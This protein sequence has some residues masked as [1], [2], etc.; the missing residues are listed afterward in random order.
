MEEKKNILIS[1]LTL[2]YLRA[3][4]NIQ[5]RIKG[6][7]RL[8][9]SNKQDKIITLKKKKSHFKDLFLPKCVTGIIQLSFKFTAIT[10]SPV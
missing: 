5:E 2:R 1:A 6:T 10:F 3:Q 9:M 7:K 4:L 8:K